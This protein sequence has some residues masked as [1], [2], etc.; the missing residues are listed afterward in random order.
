MKILCVDNDA[1]DRRIVERTLTRRFGDEL[2]L[3]TAATA[4]EAY[5]KLE[6][7]D[8]DIIF[9][10]YQLGKTT[11]LEVLNELNNKGVTSPVILLTGLGNEEVAVESL[12]LGAYDYFTK[13]QLGSER[14]IQSI[15]NI[16]ERRKAEE[17][18]EFERKKL[19]N[20][21]D[22]MVDGITITD[23][24]EKIISVNNAALKQVGYKENEVI[25][26]ILG[27]VFFE[28]KDAPRFREIIEMLASGQIIKTQEF[29]VKRKDK[30][31]FPV[32]I[33]LSFLRDSGGQPEAIVAVHRDV[34]ES[35]KREEDI[36]RAKEEAEI[37]NRTKSEF[38]ATMSHE[39]RTPMNAIIGM[40]E[41]L[42]ETKLDK[43]QNKYVDISRNAGENLLSII[44]DI[45]D[46]S[47]VEAG[48]IRLEKVG[49]N[50]VEVVEKT[51]DVMAFRAHK[52]KIEISQHINPEIPV[53]LIGDPTRLRQIFLN[54][55]GNAIK[56]TDKGEVELR[57]D[58][59]SEEKREIFK[60]ENGSKNVC[61]LFSVRDTGVGIPEDK[62]ETIFESFT[63][64]DS[65]TTRE[66]G[67][68]GLGLTICKSLIELMRG[69][70]W[71][72]S[73]VD[74]GS[75]FHFTAEFGVGEK[76]L[77]Y[78]GPGGIE[79]L[80]LKGLKTLV[81]DDT[82][83]NRLIL[84]EILTC[85][86]AK[87]VEAEDG[88]EA[89][90]TLRSSFSKDKPFELILLDC[91]MPKMGGFEFMEK[92]NKEFPKGYVTVMMLTSDNRAGDFSR[93]E[94][95]GIGAYLV[96]PVK[97]EEL[98]KAIM[99]TLRRNKV[100]A[101]KQPKEKEDKELSP[102]KILLVEDTEDNALL[103]Q[104]YL[105]KTP[106]ELD[107]AENG[108]VAVDKFKSEVYDLVLM[109]MQ[110]PVMD[111]FAA[112]E[113]IREWEKNEGRERTAIVALT[114]YTMREEVKKTLNAGCDAHLSK[115]IKKKELM[116]MIKGYE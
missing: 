41:L 45:L 79:E 35:K 9:L 5:K 54:L 58:F 1:V 39:I 21:M 13:D 81:V 114:A 6:A 102:L 84:R 85:W 52:K 15:I 61:L 64:A 112:T 55:L 18:I 96:K 40:A 77:K 99:D 97:K 80:D 82:A 30:T 88:E 23:M 69:N 100:A 104:A 51:C 76:A 109:D 106:Y 38:L 67:G 90:A 12:K 62:K 116:E 83:T 53:D 89:L 11:G 46:L 27:E 47:K 17:K 31:S 63:Q 3:E 87:V 37:A 93:I 59:E 24:E 22:S 111:G 19:Q 110:M 103:V 32:S 70:I 68:T 98:K 65:S 101:K 50:I 95:L 86:G 4:D 105:K 43:N 72:E 66:Y 36:K 20:I 115:P 57:I 91:R 26:K 74:K 108:K 78:I 29:K 48:E 16:T 60:E 10:D 2:I 42:S 28:E 33:N 14:I 44:N 94:K 113:K 107:M 75:T 56:F 8:F 92:I 73:E 25:G 7:N 71:V 49:F 34:T